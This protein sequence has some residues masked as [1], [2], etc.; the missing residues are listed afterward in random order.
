MGG[1]GWRG[2][3]GESSLVH[4]WLA[5]HFCP[6]LKS[7]CRFFFPSSD[8]RWPLSAASTQS[9]RSHLETPLQT[10]GMTGNSGSPSITGWKVFLR[11]APDTR[12][13]DCVH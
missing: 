10:P 8:R 6:D 3:R 11:A 9:L 7:L 13:Q 2:A 1:R 4:T 5:L 12:L